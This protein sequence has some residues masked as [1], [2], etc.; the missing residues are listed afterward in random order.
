LQDNRIKSFVI[1]G[2]GT[3]GWVSAAILSRVLSGT[4]CKI[5]LVESPDIPTIGVGEATIP[6]IIDML[7]FLAIS[8]NDFV[9]QTNATFK[10]GIKFIDWLREGHHYWHQF[11]NIGSRID[12]KPFYQ[13]WLKTQFFGSQHELTDFS[14]A[15]AMAKRDRFFIPDPKNPNIM[16]SS[17]FA[18]HFDAGLVAEYLADYSRVKGV[19]S[20]SANVI[21][22]QLDTGGRINSLA[23][24]NGQQLSGDFFIDCSGQ[25]GLL[26]EQALEVG[27]DNWQNYLPV[28]SA[29]VMQTENYGQLA[30]YT[31]AT[32]HEHGWRWRIPLQNRTGNGYVFCDEHCNNDTATDLLSKHV[33]GQAI[34]EPR[35]LKFVT[36]KRKKMWHKNCLAVGLSSGF[37]EPLESTSIYLIMRAML[38]F[39]QSIP[40]KD[41][42]QVTID[43]YNRLMDHEY[44]CIRDFIVLHY[45]ETE[46]TDSDFWQEWQTREI[47]DSLKTKIDLFRSQGRLFRDDMDLFAPDSW[48]AVLEG[49]GVRPKSYDPTVDV[50]DFSKIQQL[51]QKHSMAL[52]DSAEHVPGHESF[53]K[54]LL[55]Y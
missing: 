19:K 7:D 47:P 29:V 54:L 10:L 51:L 2:G 30:P 21:D 49:M 8:V 46:R 52:A 11:G 36:G 3:A 42:W 40:D 9:K 14:A 16:S 33:Q 25:K 39:V 17:T 44:E 18:L 37:L 13:H 12:G 4:D 50:S 38:N 43:E 48:Y 31:E 27:Y 26:I 1:V 23:L 55:K 41:L 35:V 45:C 34:T 32:A 20:V 6:S 15:V 53:I 5:T 28:N 24:D 22:V